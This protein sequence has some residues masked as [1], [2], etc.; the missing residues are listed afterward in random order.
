MLQ[1][2]FERRRAKRSVSSVFLAF[3]LRLKE[4]NKDKWAARVICRWWRTIQVKLREF[5][6][7][8]WLPLDIDPETA[9]FKDVDRV[10]KVL[11]DYALRKLAL[12]ENQPLLPNIIHIQRAIK[13]YL[14]TTRLKRCV[15]DCIRLI[16][17][18]KAISAFELRSQRQQLFNKHDSIWHEEID[19]IL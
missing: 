7:Q 14:I 13:S 16:S 2:L 11:D 17:G 19:Q 3:F 8:R 12:F 1:R 9:D 6:A 10:L 4:Q 15:R 18:M 5:E